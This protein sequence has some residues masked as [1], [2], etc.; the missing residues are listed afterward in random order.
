MCLENSPVVQCVQN[1]TVAVWVAVEAGGSIPGLAQW[2]KGLGVA[3]DVAQVT[4][5]AQIQ[6]MVWKLL[7]VSAAIKKKKSYRENS[8]DLMELQTFTG[9]GAHLK[10]I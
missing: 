4:A 6:P 2:V 1:L 7:Y 5:A 10:M 8:N 3:T 9:F